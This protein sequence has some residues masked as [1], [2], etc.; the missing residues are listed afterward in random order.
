MSV[1]QKALEKQQRSNA[2][3]KNIHIHTGA[4]VKQIKFA[5]RK[6]R[7]HF[8]YTTKKKTQQIEY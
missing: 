7:K 6:A 4:A 8:F 1:K 2:H 5:M 3:I